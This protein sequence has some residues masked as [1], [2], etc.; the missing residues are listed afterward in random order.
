MQ[1]WI[2]GVLYDLSEPARWSTDWQV[3][4]GGEN[5]SEQ[6][7][8]YLI[9]ISTTDNEGTASDSCSLTFDDTDGAVDLDM[10]GREIEVLLNGV[11]VF[12]GTVE[13]ARSQGSRGGGRIVPV[14]AKSFDT[15][16]KAKEAQAFHL[17]DASL[18][19]FLS[20]AA[21]EAGLAITVDPSF[22]SI[23]RDYWA[24][25]YESFLDLGEKMAREVNGTFKIR[26]KQAVLVPRGK[27]VLPTVNG[28]VGP[29]GNVIGWDLAP[30]TGRPAFTRARARWFDRKSAQYREEE[31]EIDLGRDLPDAANVVLMPMAD[32]AQAKLRT[33]GRKGEAARNAGGGTVE[34]DLTPE[35]QAE[36]PFVLSGARRDVDGGWR[37]SSV[38][39]KANRAG[40]ATTSLT[41]KEPG[42]KSGE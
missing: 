13:T 39:H 26:G 27:T 10:E 14:T 31:I 22:A 28:V 21:K 12:A 35:A 33:E 29:G 11:S 30:F 19:D 9:D 3:L 18:G 24:A 7:R 17:D 32:E 42:A 2:N 25:D 40:G 5:F 37:I 6:M 4:V 1:S 20:A 34:L 36:A 15:R 41:V 8:P 38:S 16:G 23:T